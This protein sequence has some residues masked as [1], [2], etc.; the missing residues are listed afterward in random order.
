MGHCTAMGYLYPHPV[1]A[2]ILNEHVVIS[3]AGG[4]GRESNFKRQNIS[5]TAF[6][7][8]CAKGREMGFVL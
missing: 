1:P 7:E 6:T 2:L 5:D 3:R 8:N 4:G